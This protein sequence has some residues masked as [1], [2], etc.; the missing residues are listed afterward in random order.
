MK[1]LV[2]YINEAKQVTVAD[3]K[4]WAQKAVKDLQGGSNSTYY[5]YLGDA[6]C[7]TGKMYLVIGWSGGFEKEDHKDNPNADGEYRICMKLAYNC[8]DLQ[9]DFESDWEMPYD[10]KTGDVDDTCS[11]FDLSDVDYLYKHYKKIYAE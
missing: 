3:L 2:N 6:T 7:K 1:S 8:D 10:E 4:K 9:Y 5:H 11:E